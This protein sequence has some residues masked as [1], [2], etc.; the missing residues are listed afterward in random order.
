M[1]IGIIGCGGMGRTH[2]LSLK[3]L[4]RHK[5][6]AV[7]ALADVRE[8]YLERA[9]EHFPDAHTYG[10][11][12]ELLQQESLDA[13]HI[14]LPSYLHTKH[15]LAA[16]EKGIHVLIEKPVCL[17]REEGEALLKKE[18]ETG[19]KVMVGQVLRSFREY[20]YLKQV[21]DDGQYGKLQSIVM[22]RI[23]GDVLW[24]Y[25]D[26]FHDEEKS[27][28]VV[29]DLHVHDVDFL[30]YMLGEPDRFEVK[31]TAFATGMINQILTS[32]EFG[33][34]VAM[35]EGV[36][37]VSSQTP[38]QASFRANFEK[39]VLWYNGSET[40]SLAVYKDDG[41]LEHPELESE[42]DASDLSGEMNISNLG[43]YYEEIKY[44]T[45]CVAED[46][47]VRRAPLSEGV[48]SVDLALRELNAAKEYILNR[49]K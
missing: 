2:Y 14:C 10:C 46:R 34:V 6:I 26:W 23:S 3:A 12:M 29:M 17:M 30:R 42:Y 11:G 40:P 1:K 36:W 22:Q 18:Q 19:V 20:E 8:A 38:F 47:P 4:S 33:D 16:M 13:V 45:E 43:P 35:V 28:S 5:D 41:T 21:Y 27:G 9:A 7:T 49:K 48:K 15:A 32:Y 44:F 31:A 37:N 39:A 24:G 25:E